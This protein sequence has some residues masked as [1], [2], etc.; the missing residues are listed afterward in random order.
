[1]QRKGLYAAGARLLAS[2]AAP[3]GGPAVWAQDGAAQPLPKDILDN[4][5]YIE[6][7]KG[8]FEQICKFCHGKTA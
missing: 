4:P 8:V 2:L 1:M 6:T 5:E 3:V 7:G